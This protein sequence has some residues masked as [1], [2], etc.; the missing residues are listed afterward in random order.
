MSGKGGKRF[1]MEGLRQVGEWIANRYEVFE[2]HQGGMGLVYVA[3]DHLGAA[4]ARRV[5]VKTLRDEVIADEYRRA[6][7]AS[8][9]DLWVRLG[10]HPNIVR[11]L[12]VDRSEERP[13]VVLELITGGDL[14]RWIGKPKLD[15]VHA[16]RFGVQFCLGMEHSL[17]QGLTCHR[18]IKPANLMIT[19]AGELK[20]TDF[21]LARIRD[22]FL[23]ADPLDLNAPIPLDGGESPTHSI[24]WTD[25]A[26]RDDALP[27][28]GWKTVNVETVAEPYPSETGEFPAPTPPIDQD[29]TVADS[30]TTLGGTPTLSST[31][32]WR[33]PPG[34]DAN[35]DPI[36]LTGTGLM[37]GTV[38]YMAPEQFEDAKD[39]DV[40]AD[41]Y[42]FGI[43]LYEMIAAERPFRAT[44]IDRLRHQ[45]AKAEPPSIVPA[46][47]RRH[48]REA[49][50]IDAIIQRCLAK[51]PDDRFL[52]VPELRRALTPILRRIDPASAG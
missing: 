6:R 29:L 12:A 49:E 51:D 43:V 24:R 36:R 2:I 1:T 35:A 22:E 7:F 50:R 44:T 27:G 13:H 17:R 32:D 47:P 42:A 39:A 41:I 5:A 38:P 34:A 9:C 52:T 18:D 48:Q 4:G 45:H 3:L 25:A 10:T 23:A 28:F 16:L 40:R 37:M 20:I 8:E 19:E 26:D 31:I 15:I 30:G 46:I 14:R 11:A 21:G 33:P